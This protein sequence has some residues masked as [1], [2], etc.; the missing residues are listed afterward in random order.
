MTKG[1]FIGGTGLVIRNY[2][3][4][5]YIHPGKEGGVVAVE[6]QVGILERTIAMAKLL[7]S[8][9]TIRAGKLKYPLQ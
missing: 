2:S 5:N 8:L 4:S 3:P 7:L 1:T 9:V 6:S